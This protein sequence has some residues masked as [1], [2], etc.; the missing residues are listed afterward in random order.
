MKK[1]AGRYEKRSRTFGMALVRQKVSSY[2]FALP[3]LGLRFLPSFA[4]RNE[5]SSLVPC[6]L[7]S[8]GLLRYCFAG[9][10]VSKNC[11]RP[12]F[13]ITPKAYFFH[14]AL[15]EGSPLGGRKRRSLPSDRAPLVQEA[16]LLPYPI[17]SQ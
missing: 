9:K 11:Q 2:F 10:K 6:P 4:G 5:K 16:Q 17:P 8:K 13:F 15:S 12:T 1:E 7:R 3:P 14:Y